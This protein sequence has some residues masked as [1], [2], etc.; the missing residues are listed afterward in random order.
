MVYYILYN[1]TLFGDIY[2][3]GFQL[4]KCDAQPG[5]P[6]RIGSPALHERLPAL[7]LSLHQAPVL[8][9]QGRL[10]Q[11]TCTYSYRTPICWTI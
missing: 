2:S 3:V 6:Q 10:P 11:G 8:G 4:W 9:R 7:R 5:V 1:A